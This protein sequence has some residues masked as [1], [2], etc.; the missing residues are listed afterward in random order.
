MRFITLTKADAVNLVA[1]LHILGKD[2]L[3]L[4]LSY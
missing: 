2:F 3:C 4:S 1:F